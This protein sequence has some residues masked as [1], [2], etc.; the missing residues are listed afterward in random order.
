MYV[1]M[2][3]RMYV[4]ACY[5]YEVPSVTTVHMRTSIYVHRHMYIYI[6]I[7]THIYIH[8]QGS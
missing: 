3:V 7:D 6:C 8:I 1:C 5:W 2:Y 4:V